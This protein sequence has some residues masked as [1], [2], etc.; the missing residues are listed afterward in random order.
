MVLAGTCER[1]YALS[2]RSG[3]RMTGKISVLYSNGLQI[4]SSFP[5]ASYE[6]VYRSVEAKQAAHPLYEHFSGA[7]NALAYRFRAT[8]DRGD[9]FIL[10][11]AQHGAEPPPE[12]RYLQ[13][14]LLFEFFSSGF[15]AFEAAFYGFYTI[16]AFTQPTGFP[17]S[18]PKD[19]QR[20][21]PAG[22]VNA[23]VRVYSADKVAAAL[24][25][26]I[27]DPGFQQ[28]REVRN[29]LTH[30]TAPG[31]RMYVGLGIDDAPPTEWKLNNLPIDGTI[32]TNSV[33]EL[34]RLLSQLLTIIEG[35]TQRH[36]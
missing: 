11:F 28:F 29:I 19:Q 4:P 30:R 12:E 33:K 7:W 23:F 36:V 15:S 14:C 26:F 35:F 32:I 22:A 1:R 13:E 21:S 8:I 20:V 34:S 25:G 17:L 24:S 5:I 2:Q 18:T 9:E 3:C 16:G 31:R 10:A 27:A 6:I